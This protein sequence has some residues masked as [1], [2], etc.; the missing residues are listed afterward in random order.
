[1]KTF[2]LSLAFT[3][4]SFLLFNPAHGAHDPAPSLLSSTANSPALER[5]VMHQLN[6]HVIFPLDAEEGAMCGVVDVAI[7]VDVSG[8]LVVKEAHSDNRE[9]RDYVVRKLAKV[10]VGAN[11]SGMWN[12]TH[13]RFTFKPQ[14]EQL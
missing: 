12:T 10:H 6:R 5:A 7:A 1:M 13:V 2:Q 9:L 4:G 11:P 3:V 8:H 14:A